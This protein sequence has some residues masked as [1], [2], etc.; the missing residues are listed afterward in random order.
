MI[1]IQLD[2]VPVVSKKNRLKFGKGRTYK[3]K[4]VQDFEDALAKAAA[5]VV[6]NIPDWQP[7]TGDLQLELHVQ[8]PDKRRRD[9]HNCFDTVCDSLQNIVYVDDNQIF[10]VYG[11]KTIGKR[12]SLTVTV[13]EI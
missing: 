10:Q 6:C 5:E 3:P 7:L 11:R 8:F 13:T 2:D 4:E 9:I 12:W 1:T